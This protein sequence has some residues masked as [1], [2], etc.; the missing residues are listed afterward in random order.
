MKNIRNLKDN[1]S[2]KEFTENG[3]T[4]KVPEEEA[5]LCNNKKTFLN[6]EKDNLDRE[7]AKKEERLFNRDLS[8]SLL[9]QAKVK[10]KSKTKTTLFCCF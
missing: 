3:I 4:N 9:N 5:F 6:N 7:K 2:N 10:S 1:F 8:K